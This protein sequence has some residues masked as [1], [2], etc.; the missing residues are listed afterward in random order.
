MEEVIDSWQ[1]RMFAT[2][3]R[4][5]SFTETARRMRLTQSAVSHALRK[6]EQDLGRR[7]L[8]R[9]GRRVDLTPA[10]RRLLLCADAVLAQMTR[11]RADLAGMG[12]DPAGRLRIVCPADAARRLLPPVLEEFR[13]LFP[14]CAVR[15]LP[16]EAVDAPSL[17][18]AREADFLFCPETEETARLV[19]RPVFTD[20]PALLLNA[21]AVAGKEDYPVLAAESVGPCYISHD[22]KGLPAN[23]VEA[24]LRSQGA[25]GVTCVEIGSTEA[26]LELVKLNLGSG[27]AP[28]W[29]AA[30]SLESGAVRA[31]HAPLAEL[32]RRW[33][34]LHLPDREFTLAEE[35]FVSLCRNLRAREKIHE[36][37]ECQSGGRVIQKRAV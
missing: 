18:A 27:V 17:L 9:R 12:E 29:A 32:R 34:L 2:L 4:T 30:E 10:G 19:A 11:A 31:F 8:E 20:T 14:A 24:L 37:S 33:S 22:P 26:L 25:S 21:R 36:E 23:R 6:L 15:V 7:L 13:K 28:V 35:T 3:S 16:A 1:L 5:G